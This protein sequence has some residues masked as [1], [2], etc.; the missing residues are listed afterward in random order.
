MKHNWIITITL[1]GL[2]LLAQVIGLSIINSYVGSVETGKV[3][4]WKALPAIAGYSMER[5]DVS[6]GVSVIYIV[7]ALIIGT[8]LILLIIR[9]QKVS[10]WKL[11][12]WLAVVL[13]LHIAFAAFIPSVYALA[14][15]VLLGSLKI[16]RPGVLVHNATELFIY[17]GLA[18]IF[19]PLLTPIYAIGLLL[20]I[21]LYDM[22]AV[23]KS[24]HM[25]DMAQFQAKS[26]I[27]AGM[28]LPYSPKKLVFKAPKKPGI[29]RTA[30]LGGGDVGFPLIFAGVILKTYG[31][32]QSVIIAL[33]ATAALL[34]LL[35]FGE[36]KKFYP[37]MPF[38]TLGC[39]AG[40]GLLF[41][42]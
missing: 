21:S 11:W 32:Q 20:L 6:P 27:F 4:E 31:M 35:Y 5:P 25:A 8:A 41:L 29:V 38:L 28:L 9:W 12:Y 16:L 42:L 14:L 22:Y 15:A 19:V 23:W 24:R 36:K 3:T 34:G 18:V 13:C 10:L 1:V 39:L 30:I 40:Y 33:G 7:I 2:F 26:G 17:G 37:A